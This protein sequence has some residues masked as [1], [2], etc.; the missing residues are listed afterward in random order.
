MAAALFD[1]DIEDVNPIL[2]LVTFSDVKDILATTTSVRAIFDLGSDFRPYS[3]DWVGVFYAGWGSTNEYIAYKFAPMLPKCLK[4]R[5]RRIRSVI[6]PLCDFLDVND[7]SAKYQ[8]LYVTRDG[9]V[10]GVS[11]MFQLQ[12]CPGYDDDLC[13]DVLEESCTPSIVHPGYDTDLCFDVL[14]KSY[15]FEV[16]ENYEPRRKRS[17]QNCNIGRRRGLVGPVTERLMV[18]TARSLVP[19]VS[20]HITIVCNVLYEK[21]VHFC[22]IKCLHG[23]KRKDCNY[24]GEKIVHKCFTFKLHQTNLILQ[25]SLKFQ[26]SEFHL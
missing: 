21:N 15:S 23:A 18:R 14:E 6:F 10:V 25:L 16:I 4:T 13:F 20:R 11:R 26:D 1:V 5:L 24:V 9:H 19:Q 17:K 12:C 3:Y 2:D 7:T 22:L 8:F